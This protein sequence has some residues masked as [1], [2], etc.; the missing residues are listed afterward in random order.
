MAELFPAWRRKARAMSL[1]TIGQ[2]LK[3]LLNAVENEPLPIR[4]LEIKDIRKSASEKSVQL[5]TIQQKPSY[6]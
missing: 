6:L 2:M 4:I 3:T 1:V 5:K